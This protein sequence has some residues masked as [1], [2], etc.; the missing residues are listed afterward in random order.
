MIETRRDLFFFVVCFV[1][2]RIAGQLPGNVNPLMIYIFSPSE[3]LVNPLVVTSKV[4][5]SG[6]VIQLYIMHANTHAAHTHGMDSIINT[7]TIVP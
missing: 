2:Q 6:F 7:F 1:I 5:V 3:L 4:R